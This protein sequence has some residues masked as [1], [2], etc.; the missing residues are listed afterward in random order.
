MGKL[1][2]IVPVHNTDA[3][4][5]RCLESV[6]NQTLSD[7][8]VILVEN[9][10]T[11]SSLEMCYKYQRNDPRVKVLHLEIGDLST[12]RNKGLEVATSE[13]VAFIDSDDYISVDMYERLYSLASEED[14]DLVY[15]N[16]V[17]VYDDR[18]P[19]YNYAET[20]KVSVMSPKELLMMNFCY[21]IPLHSCTMIVRRS[22]FDNLKFPEFV[23][24][25]DRAVTY[26]LINS[27]KRVGYIDKAFYNYYQRRGS[28]VHSMNWKKYYDFAH[29]EYERLKFLKESQLFTDEEKLIAAEKGAR[30]YIRM[31]KNSFRKAKT[32]QQKKLSKDLCKGL[33]LIPEGC[34]LPYKTRLYR[35]MISLFY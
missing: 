23:F 11:D 14:L 2:V 6:L 16:H 30:M 28:I 33:A 7:I 26:L 27:S 21:K 35:S 4:L 31:L 18:P 3:Y 20:G 8:E 17:L 10:S 34:R 25:E 19:R 5:D 22:L 32:E 12:A 13:Y 29:A 24:F 15:S 1:S 9:A